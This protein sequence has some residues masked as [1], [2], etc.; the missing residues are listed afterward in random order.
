MTIK[1]HQDAEMAELQGITEEMANFCF[2]MLE[3]SFQNIGKYDQDVYDRI[4]DIEIEVNR[5]QMKIDDL[6]WKIIALYQPTAGD[7]RNLIGTIKGA[8]D[9]ERIADEICTFCRRSMTLRNYQ[10]KELPTT[11]FDLQNRVKEL[12]KN[13]FTAIFSK[14]V[15][16]AD[17]ILLA[18]DSVDALF[19]TL[20]EWIRD[21]MKK[22]P[23]RIDTLLDFLSMGRSLERIGDHATNL[24]E[25]AIFV[26]KGTDVRHH[27]LTF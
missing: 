24:A 1:R 11:L 17:S 8:V 14:D 5:H 9:M 3:L 21:E 6:A 26:E 27:G 13:G 25:I 22:S 12:L 7:L 4:F 16:L 2:T 20:F 10:W 19:Q 15:V 18:D 23:D